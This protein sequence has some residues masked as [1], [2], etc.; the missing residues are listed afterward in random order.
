MKMKSKLFYS[1]STLYSMTFPAQPTVLKG[2]ALEDF[3][4][5]AREVFNDEIDDENVDYT[6]AQNKLRTKLT[7]QSCQADTMSSV[8][9]LWRLWQEVGQTDQYVFTGYQARPNLADA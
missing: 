1:S 4:A 6:T 2:A 5:E 8:E 9:N 3:L 7:Q